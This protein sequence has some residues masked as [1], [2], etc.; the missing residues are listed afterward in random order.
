VSHNGC[1]GATCATA[2]LTQNYADYKQDKKPFWFKVK[3]RKYQ[4]SN[5]YN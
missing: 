3:Q 2:H 1:A 5:N 4:R